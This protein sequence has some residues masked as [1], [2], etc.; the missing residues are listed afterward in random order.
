MKGNDQVIQ[1]LNEVLCAELTAVNQY[2]V[3]SM[4]CRNWGY[5]KLAEYLRKE[6]IGEMKHAQEVIE[7]IL[8]LEGVPNMQKYFKINVGQNVRQ[9][10]EFDVAVEYDA[11]KRLN[12]G[13]E[14]ATK[15]SDNG[16]RA[17]LEGILRSEEEH[18]DW[19]E[20]QLH[21][22]QEAGYENYLAQ[23]LED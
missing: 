21:V 8:Y 4:M 15:A 18:I 11:V 6:S 2:F 5:R 12:D 10:M 14:V 19:L 17:I 1:V 22:I 9:Q 20:A 3:H 16:S 23:Q 13:I 7:R